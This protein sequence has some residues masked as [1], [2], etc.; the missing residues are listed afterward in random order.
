[1]L[2]GPV[3]GTG[4]TGNCLGGGHFIRGGIYYYIYDILANLIIPPSTGKINIFGTYSIEY[5]RN[6]QK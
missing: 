4:K 5:R 3:E 1:M 2:K 6:G